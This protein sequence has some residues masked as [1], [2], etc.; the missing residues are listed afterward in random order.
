LTEC[1]LFAAIT[2]GFNGCS[3]SANEQRPV[4]T[5]LVAASLLECVDEI[6]AASGVRETVQVD[7]SSAASSS[8]ARQIIAGAPAD[9]FLS[10]SREWADEIQKQIP[11]TQS[12]ILATNRL[13]LVAPANSTGGI[14]SL[15]DFFR[16]PDLRLGIGEEEVPAG[17]YSSQALR[18]LEMLDVLKSRNQLVYGQDVRQVLKW[19]DLR[20]VDGGLVYASDAAVSDN[21]VEVATI[22]DALH[23]R[24]EYWI[25][26]LPREKAP[27]QVAELF[28]FLRSAAAREILTR[29]GFGLVD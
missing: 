21:V 26:R 6:V 16:E 24:I 25:V 15:D 10:A 12:E 29:H 9:L 1:L 5:I 27:A 11:K 18:K 19:T 3:H 8:L 14:K 4:V 23:D 13:V 17:K 20:E 2:A 28:V 22:D 7:I